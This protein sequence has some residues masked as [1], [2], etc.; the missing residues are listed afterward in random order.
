MGQAMLLDL[1][2]PALTAEAAPADAVEAAEK[3]TAQAYGADR[4]FFLVNGSTQ[5]IQAGILALAGPGEPIVVPRHSHR[6]VAA[7]LALAGADPLFVFTPVDPTWGIPRAITAEDVRAA[8]HARR[9]KW[10]I[11]Q[12]DAA[13]NALVTHPNYWGLAEPVRAIG[14]VITSTGG[15]LMCVE[16]HGAHLPFLPHGPAPALALGAS[17]AVQSPHKMLGSLVQSAW[18][19]VK[20][21]GADLQRRLSAAVSIL[22]T[23]SPSFLLLSSLDTTRRWAVERGRQELAAAADMALEVRAQIARFE[24]IACLTDDDA[25]NLGYAGIDPLKL[26]IGPRVDRFNGLDVARFL[27]EEYRIQVEMANPLYV[28][29]ILSP[30]DSRDS[31]RRLVEALSRLIVRKPDV[32]ASAS[33]EERGRGAARARGLIRTWP[34]EQPVR[35]MSLREAVFATCR[36]VPLWEYSQ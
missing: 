25:R 17:I 4:S 30:G 27:R 10:L 29:L 31:G 15:V 6:S 18:M 12:H 1:D 33:A 23:S 7:G 13:V 19:H 20:G 26:T 34:T 32:S 11:T 3:L 21:G 9:T 35:A 36:E 24:E 5:G 28:T 2:P 16:A 14:E 8:V 22:G